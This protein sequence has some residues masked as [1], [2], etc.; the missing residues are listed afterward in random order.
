M[1]DKVGLTGYNDLVNIG[2]VMKKILVTGGAGFIGSHL[3]ERLVEA[4][5]RVICV[6]NMITGNRE[7]VRGLEGNEKFEFVGGDVAEPVERYWR[8][9]QVEWIFHLASPASPRGYQDAP[10]ETYKVNSFGTHYLAEYASKVGARMLFASTSEVYGDPLEHPQKEEYRGNVNIRGVRSC[11]DVSKRFGEMVQTVWARAK[12]LDMRTVRIFNTY[13]PRMDPE[14]GR[15][16]PN[17]ISQALGN[18]PMTV[19]GDGSQT[20]SFCFV[21]DLVEGL[22]MVMESKETAGEVYNLGNPDEYTVLAMA[23]KIKEMVGTEVEIVHEALPEDDPAKRRPD[24][25]KITKAVG[26]RPQVGLDEGLEKTIEY[27]RSVID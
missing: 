13:G 16:F 8:G 25:E 27:F 12:G 4:G 17:F 3:C 1:Y 7:N 18:K 9:E 6:D 10:I 21:D 11:Y 14:D 22:K 26:W 19:Y 20:R 23:E 5:H 15:V 2:R 24:I